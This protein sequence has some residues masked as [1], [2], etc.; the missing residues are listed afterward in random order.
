MELVLDTALTWSWRLLVPEKVLMSYPLSDPKLLFDTDAQEETQQLTIF[1]LLSALKNDGWSVAEA[2]CPTRRKPSFDCETMVPKVLYP[3]HRGLPNRYYLLAL[4]K[5]QDLSRAGVQSIEHGST[6][7]YYRGLM[8]QVGMDVG[9]Q[10]KK[11][12]ASGA[13]G[14]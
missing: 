12:K 13:I 7:K 8:A 1:Q 5:A 6:Q 3:P 14:D 4:M 10:K 11:Q 2:P 9:A